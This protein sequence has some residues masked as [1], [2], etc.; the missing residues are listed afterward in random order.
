MTFSYDEFHNASIHTI[1]HKLET[2][3]QTL[4]RN[5]HELSR[6]WCLLNFS[7]SNPNSEVVSQDCEQMKSFTIVLTAK[8]VWAGRSIFIKWSACCMHCTGMVWTGQHSWIR[9]VGENEKA[10]KQLS[11]TAIMWYSVSWTPSFQSYSSLASMNEEYF[12]FTQ[13]KFSCKSFL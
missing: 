9:K 2:G 11:A 5:I 6:V 12:L 8:V 1:Q 4:T 3:N 10:Q 7:F 13:Q